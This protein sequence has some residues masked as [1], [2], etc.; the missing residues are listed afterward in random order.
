MI[1][2]FVTKI[3]GLLPKKFV[4]SISYKVI[5]GYVDKYAKINVK[6]K[7]NLKDI[8]KPVL[9]VCNHLSNSDALILKRVIEDDDVTFVAGIKLNS[10]SLTSMGISIVKTTPIHPNTAD[11]EGIKKII[12]I[13]KNGGSVVVF[14]EGTRSRTGKLIEAK[15]GII[16]IAKMC[17]VPIVPIG[18]TGT[19]KL[20]PI[21]EEGQMEKEKFHYSDINVNI[22]QQFLLPKKKEEETGKEYEIRALEFLMKKIADLLPEEYRGVY[23]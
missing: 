2:P 14:P 6:N 1:S 5:N 13:I 21:N 12:S 3:I 7:E 8:K 23:L 9:Y 4:K 11:K 15:R 16:L 20:L 17:K 10:N 19:E 22:G 18:M